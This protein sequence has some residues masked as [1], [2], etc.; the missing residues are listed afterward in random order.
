MSRERSS[1]DCSTQLAIPT[2]V[3][4]SDQASIKICQPGKKR[5]RTEDWRSNQ[6]IKKHLP[7]GEILAVRLEATEA[8]SSSNESCQ[9]ASGVD[10]DKQQENLRCSRLNPENLGRFNNSEGF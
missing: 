5:R 8:R 2:L 6:E 7:P 10:I 1:N 9:G 4:E 3:A